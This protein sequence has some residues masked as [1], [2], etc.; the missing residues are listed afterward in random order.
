MFKK[1]I[2]GILVIVLTLIG[3][4]VFSAKIF[5]Q[6]EKGWIEGIV[7]IEDE[8]GELKT[9][10][11]VKGWSN[12]TGHAKVYQK[13]KNIRMFDTIDMSGVFMIEDLNPGT[14]NLIIELPDYKV[15]NIQK[16][17]VKSGQPTVLEIVMSE[18][19]AGWQESVV[20]SSIVTIPSLNKELRAIHGDLTEIKK[21]LQEILEQE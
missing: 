5:A 6:N 2:N 20:T 9:P 17:E 4:I 8:E 1:R 3:T 10:P 16:V 13:G 11:K 21:M 15:A 7:I 18:K 14:Y 19:G 12:F